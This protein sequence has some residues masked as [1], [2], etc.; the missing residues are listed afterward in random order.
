MAGFRT[1]K[2]LDHS[3][4]SNSSIIVGGRF[5]DPDKCV[6]KH[7]LKDITLKCKFDHSIPNTS[8]K[9]KKMAVCQNWML[10]HGR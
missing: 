8:D 4:V 2:V 9:S 5:S 3:F 6:K 1:Y 7:L 10:I